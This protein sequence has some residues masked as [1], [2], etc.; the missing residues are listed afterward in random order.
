[1]PGLLLVL[2]AA[3]PTVAPRAIEVPERLAA[4]TSAPELSGLVWCPPLERYLVVSDDTG[5]DERGTRRAPFLLAM[6][7]EGRLDEAPVPIEGTDGLDDAESIADGPEG[8]YFLV[9]SHAPN[10]KGRLRPARRQLL[11]LRLEARSLVVVGRADLTRLAG[12]T[13]QERLGVAPDAS[14]DIEAVAFAEGAVYLGLKAPL[15]TSGQA[16]LARVED[17]VRQLA[18]G[19]V[20]AKSVSRWASPALCVEGVCQGIADLLLRPDGAALVVANA[21]K[22]SPDD[23][24]GALWR[25]TRGRPPEL[26][27]RFP[28]LRPEGLALG[29]RGALAVVFDRREEVP[30]WVEL[31]LPG[32]TPSATPPSSS[33]GTER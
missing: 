8:T 29:P 17:A 24:G 11:H 32:P 12:G 22:G 20:R 10:R 25:L 14:L 3:T 5:L 6:T 7:A 31:P 2:V 15:S 18:T 30:W 27:R 26:L 1:M 33:A 28:G 13:L 9:T 23:G 19:R 21:P 4:Q 16:Y